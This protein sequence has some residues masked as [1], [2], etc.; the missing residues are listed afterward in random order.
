MRREIDFVL[1]LSQ[2]ILERRKAPTSAVHQA[3]RRYGLCVRF[4]AF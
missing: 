3:S 2:L 4:S 1:T